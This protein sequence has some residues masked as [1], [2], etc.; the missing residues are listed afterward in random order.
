MFLRGHQFWGLI[1]QRDCAWNDILK[2][3]VLHKLSWTLWLYEPY[4]LGNKLFWVAATVSDGMILF[5]QN[6]VYKA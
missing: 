2:I 3:S 5:V 4:S 1:L 6:G